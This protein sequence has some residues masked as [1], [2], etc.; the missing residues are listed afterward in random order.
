MS[1]QIPLTQ[2][3]AEA[4]QLLSR[5]MSVGRPETKYRDNW[6]LFQ[7]LYASAPERFV[8]SCG[9]HQNHI[10]DRLH[11]SVNVRMN[12]VINV[13]IHFNGFMLPNGGFFIS[14]VCRKNANKQFEIIFETAEKFA[15]AASD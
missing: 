8:V 15:C 10:S 5:F 2:R 13:P 4:S 9:I 7:A 14:E 12:D 1:S 11:F 3:I 6:L